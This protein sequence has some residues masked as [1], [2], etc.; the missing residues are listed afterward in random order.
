MDLL[1]IFQV[2]PNIY[3]EIEKGDLNSVYEWLKENVHEC[4][5]LYDPSDLIKR[6]TGEELQA[7]YFIEYLDNKYKKIY[8]Y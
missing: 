1:D 7:K 5:N 3:D 6:I 8:N 4:A 2:M